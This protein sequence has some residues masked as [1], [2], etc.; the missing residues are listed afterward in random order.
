MKGVKKGFTL[1]E[2]VISMTIVV[3]IFAIVSSIYSSINKNLKIYEV[4]KKLS[5]IPIQ[6]WRY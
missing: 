1:L 2:V 5:I 3:M 4:R 6:Q